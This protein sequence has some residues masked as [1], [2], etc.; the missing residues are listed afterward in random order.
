MTNKCGR[1]KQRT[2]NLRGELLLGM[3]SA[4]ELATVYYYTRNGSQSIP[5]GYKDWCFIAPIEQ[6]S[7]YRHIKLKKKDLQSSMPSFRLFSHA[8]ANYKFGCYRKTYLL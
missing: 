2:N 1:T 7:G 3:N 5:P 6:Y 8:V 4:S